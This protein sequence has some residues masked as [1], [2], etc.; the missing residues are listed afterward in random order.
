MTAKAETEA[1]PAEWRSLRKEGQQEWR[2][3]VR[4][5][6]SDGA[7]G[8][9]QTPLDHPCGPP[10]PTTLPAAFCTVLRP[11]T[12]AFESHKKEKYLSW[13]WLAFVV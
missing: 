1:E 2:E 6:R 3:Q 4:P 10:W 12:T 13:I 7:A 8:A 9:A 11:E 5:E